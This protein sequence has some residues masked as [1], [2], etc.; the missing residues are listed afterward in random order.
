ME[1]E[2]KNLIYHLKLGSEWAYRQLFDRHYAILCRV[3]YEF[4]KDR[5]L[6]ESTVNDV[7][8]YLWENRKNVEIKTSLRSYLTAAVRYSCMNHLQ[9]KHVQKEISLSRL[10]DENFFIGLSIQ[11]GEY[12][13]G[14][15]LKKE[16][17]EKIAQSIAQLPKECQKVFRM[18]RF[19]NMNY[20]DISNELSISVNTVKY[21]IKNAIAKL[22]KDLDKYLMMLTIV[23]NFF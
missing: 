15:L 22:R 9:K 19:E 23:Y 7:I 1:Q 14:M 17:E 18:S 16:L 11:P 21:H 12:P 6:A 2:E 10:E 20:E 5:F 3:A 8:V 4:L 13:L